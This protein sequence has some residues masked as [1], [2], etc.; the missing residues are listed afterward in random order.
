MIKNEAGEKCTPKDLANEILAKCLGLNEFWIRRNPDAITDMTE[1][2]LGMFNDQVAKQAARCFKILGYKPG[3]VVPHPG[4]M[5]DE[6]IADE[7]I[8]ET[9]PI[10]NSDATQDKPD[11]CL[12]PAWELT[13]PPRCVEC[14]LEQSPTLDEVN[15]DEDADE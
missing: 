15:Y 9:E 10:H 1:R 12:H 6:S 5:A 11:A 8:E 7:V 14:G 2:E 4:D 3:E 13:A